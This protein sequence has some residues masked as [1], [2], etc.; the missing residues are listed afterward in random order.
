MSVSDKNAGAYN[1]WDVQ[2]T[3]TGAIDRGPN[4]SDMWVVPPYPTNQAGQ[5]VYFFN[6]IQTNG[7][8][9]TLILQPVLGFNGAPPWNLASWNCCS[10]G[11]ASQSEAVSVNPGD[12]IQGM[13]TSSNCDSS[14]NCQSWKVTSIDR[15]T[16][17]SVVLNAGPQEG[18][19]WAVLPAVLETYG[20]TSCDMFPPNGELTFFNNDYTGSNGQVLSVNYQLLHNV[21]GNGQNGNLPACGYGGA[22]G[23]SSYTLIFG[24]SPTGGLEPPGGVDAGPFDPGPGCVY[25]S[26]SA[27]QTCDGCRMVSNGCSCTLRCDYCLDGAGGHG[28]SQTLPLPCAGDVG[29]N[30][31]TLACSTGAPDLDACAPPQSEAGVG[32][33]GGMGGGPSADG[34]K[35]ATV[36]SNPGTDAAVANPEDAAVGSQ[37]TGPTG[38]P[39]DGSSASCTMSPSKDRLGGGSLPLAAF[40]VLLLVRSARR[41]ADKGLQTVAS[42]R[43]RAH[44]LSPQVHATRIRCASRPAQPYWLAAFRLARTRATSSTRVHQRRPGVFQPILS[45]AKRASRGRRRA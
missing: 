37:G 43:M 38:S 32:D 1:G 6:G 14:G 10:S 39:P 26:A 35:D 18:V 24:T 5:V 44:E 42:N 36:G 13:V 41:R 25:G 40:A 34:G 33:D 22:T 16:G 29:N 21:G 23:A 12:L 45:L 3:Y 19:A 9:G 2:Y 4:L 27:L 31:G 11:N 20:V 7:P 28:P 8:Q 30:N 15:T 17:F